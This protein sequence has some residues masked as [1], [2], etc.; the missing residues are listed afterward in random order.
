MWIVMNQLHV[1]KGASRSGRARF[2]TTKGI[3]RMEGFHR[4]QVLVD[5]S[6]EEEDIVTIMTTWSNQASIPCVARE[7]SVQRR[8]P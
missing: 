8:A 7:S 3:E 6:Q 4:M 1:V 2:K 5:I